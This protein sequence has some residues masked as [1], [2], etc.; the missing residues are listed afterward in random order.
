MMYES[1]PN[2]KTLLLIE[3]R[4]PQ[5]TDFRL[6]KAYRVL[7]ILGLAIGLFIFVSGLIWFLQQA[8]LIPLT[9]KI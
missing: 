7:S 3:L 1:V 8:N 9:I 2:V 6:E 5:E 4:P